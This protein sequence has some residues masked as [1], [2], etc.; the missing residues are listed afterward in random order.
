MQLPAIGFVPGAVFQ[1]M[2][3]VGL[4]VAG[5]PICKA[6]QDSF[7]VKDPGRVVWDEFATVPIVFWLLPA[8]LLFNAGVLVVGFALHRLFDVLK[9][10]PLAQLERFP[11]GLGIMADD[12]VAGLYSCIILQS[13]VAVGVVGV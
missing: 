3:I 2:I 13:L 10:P 11:G 9:P 1:A 5:I 12:V 7:N 6:G 4:I 8:P